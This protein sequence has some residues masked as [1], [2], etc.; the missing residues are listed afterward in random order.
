MVLKT[1]WNC[2]ENVKNKVAE[3]CKVLT[4]FETTFWKRR[5][6]FEN[7]VAKPS[8]LTLFETIF[9]NCQN[10]L[11]VPFHQEAS[12]YIT[13]TVVGHDCMTSYVP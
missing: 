13:F 3:A 6:H 1:I 9:C 7:K 10:I 4:L 2:R 12:L 11:F 5:E 8:L